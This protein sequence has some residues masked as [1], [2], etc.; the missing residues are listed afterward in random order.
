MQYTTRKMKFNNSP[1]GIIA[2]QGVG[3]NHRNP[4]SSAARVNT[5]VLVTITAR[6]LQGI[7]HALFYNANA[8]CAAFI[9][10]NSN[11][12]TG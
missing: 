10:S 5:Q 7:K 12:V 9:C 3:N 2:N 6:I 8:H 1:I 4:V 11:I